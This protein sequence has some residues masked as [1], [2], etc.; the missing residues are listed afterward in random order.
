VLEIYYSWY[1]ICSEKAL[2]CLFE[3]DLPF[4]GRHVDLFDFDQVRDDYL[5]ID[6]DGVVPAL[7][8]DGRPVYES[9]VINEYLEDIAPEPALRPGDAYQRADM[10]RWVQLFQD[11]VFPAAGLL[12]QIAFIADEL[13]R[14]WP[15]DELEAL[16]HRKINTDRVA[17]QLRAVRGEL[18]TREADAALAKIGDVLDRAEH[19]LGDGREWIAGNYSL[20]DAAAAP[21]LYRFE[22]IGRMDLIDRRPAVASWYRRI[23]ARPAF[24][25]AYEYSPSVPA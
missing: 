6:P 21:N 3:K 2:I 8:H 12:S 23:K 14:R 15:A 10:R 7:I 24:R 22:I 5:A 4:E 18:T 1:S 17:R 13:N 20:A 19:A 25:R 11:V 9:T 16:I